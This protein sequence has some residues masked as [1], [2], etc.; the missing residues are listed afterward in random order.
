MV[1]PSI[2]RVERVACTSSIETK[3]EKI[4]VYSQKIGYGEQGEGLNP[5][6]TFQRTKG[7]VQIGDK[8]HGH[9]KVEESPKEMQEH[10]LQLH[11]IPYLYSEI[12]PLFEASICRSN[13]VVQ[14]SHQL[15]HLK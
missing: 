12:I 2:S 3:F 9:L 14:R 11:F 8:I 15:V 1:D 5:E 6:E 7:P 10:Y 13:A 4:L